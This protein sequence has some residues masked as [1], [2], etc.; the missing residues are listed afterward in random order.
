MKRYFERLQRG[1]GRAFSAGL[2]WVDASGIVRVSDARRTRAPRRR[3][4]VVLL[5]GHADATAVRERGHQQ[6]RG[7]R[8]RDRHG[9]ADDG[10]AAAAITGV[11]SAALLNRPFAITKSTLDLGGSASSV[12]DRNGRSL[13]DGSGDP[14]NLSLVA[15]LRGTGVIADTP[16]LTEPIDHAVAYTASAIP[17]WTIVID[18]PRSVLFADARRGLFLELALVAAAASIVLFL[19]G[20]ILLRGRRAAERERTRARQR[21]DLSRILGS[22]S[23]AAEVSDGLVAGLAEP[24]R[25]R[26][27]SSRWT[28]RIITASSSPRRPR[29][30]SPRAPT[31]ATSGLAGGDAG[32][33]LRRA[34]S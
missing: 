13:L 10:F 31:R 8:A 20:L 23:P 25:A 29:E 6:P 2:G 14:T 17:G 24:S 27:A 15:S 18:Q 34:R 16:G 33:R 9:R 7:R 3:R 30:R 5:E 22:A 19:I 32:L 12:L 28:P 21:R 1:E 4:P 11:L 26:S